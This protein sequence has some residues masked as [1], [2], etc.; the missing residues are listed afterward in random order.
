M[1]D[2]RE[3]IAV[4]DTPTPTHRQ[5]CE[6]QSLSLSQLS[7]IVSLSLISYFICLKASNQSDLMQH[8]VPAAIFHLAQYSVWQSSALSAR[9]SV[10]R[11]ACFLSLPFLPHTAP[12][13]TIICA[14]RR[15]TWQYALRTATQYAFGA[16]S[17]FRWNVSVE[18]NVRPSFSLAAPSITLV[19]RQ[20]HSRRR[21]RRLVRSRRQQMAALNF[22][23][24]FLW[25]DL[26]KL[27]EKSL[28]I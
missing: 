17:A 18:K 23:Y 26:S 14:R 25:N 13:W 7:K 15:R 24:F 6:S 20:L 10:R 11:A 22:Y 5:L 21:R 4:Q 28:Q 9:H 16:S 8:N 12:H 1:S 3:R 27:I 19:R 2:R